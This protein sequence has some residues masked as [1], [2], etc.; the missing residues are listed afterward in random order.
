MLYFMEYADHGATIARATFAAILRYDAA[1][2]NRR[3]PRRAKSA[4]I[5]RKMR[6]IFDEAALRR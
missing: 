6:F 1:S 4:S 5:L 3:Y 2:E